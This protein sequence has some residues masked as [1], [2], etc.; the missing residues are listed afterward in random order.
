MAFVP[1]LFAMILVL[2]LTL[3]W[4]LTQVVDYARELIENIPH[5]L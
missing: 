3:P 4:L 1:K 2:S 5:T